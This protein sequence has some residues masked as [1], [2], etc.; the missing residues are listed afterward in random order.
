MAEWTGILE[1]SIFV[2]DTLRC[3]ATIAAALT[4]SPVS[5]VFSL[6][7]VIP[8]DQGDWDSNLPIQ[9]NERILSGTKVDSF[10][11][12]YYYR[13]HVT[14]LTIA[15]GAI[16]SEVV[17]TFI[18]WNA[19]FDEVDML[20]IVE[21]GGD[22]FALAGQTAPYTFKPLEYET[23]TVTVPKEG[24]P[25]LA[26]SI[27]FDFDT[28][29]DRTVLITGIRMIV[30]AFCPQVEMK[31]MLE[32][33]TDIIMPNDG[34]GSEQRICVRQIPRQSFTL[35]VP[36]KTEKEQARFEAAMF[37]WQKR[38]FGL[39]I[40]TERVIHTAAINA[41]DMTI[42]IDTTNADFRDDSYAVIW[43][44]LTEYEA[45]KIT[46]VAANLLTLESPVVASYTGTKFI[47]PCRIAQVPTAARKSNP[48]AAVAIADISFAI[49]DNILLTGYTPETTYLGLP[50]LLVG[51][52][53]FGGSPK[54][55]QI[56]SDSFT[57][58]YESG[59]F[60]YFSDSE[61]NLIS[62][63]W[64]FVNVTR[65]QCWNFRKFLHSLYGRQGTFWAP[66]YKRDLIQAETIGA[67]DTNFQIENIKLAEN[68]TFN[69][70]RNHLAFIFTS[71]TVL[72]RAITGIVESDEDIEIV[73]I[74]SALGVEVDI[75]DCVISFLDLCRLASDSVELD[76]FFFDK[77]K[78][79]T[80]F[81]TV[82]E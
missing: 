27:E 66:T 57:Q 2:E 13:V 1:P 16:L 55:S 61:F 20:S 47:L 28:G 30:F 51:S 67:A 79:E 54:E 73:S 53:Q 33:L 8:I 45:V 43:K 60:D 74:D 75:G 12:D 82:K 58:D 23:Y 81:L 35:S 22:E 71:G 44:S 26:S 41:T 4:P 29:E 50:V 76:W 62:Q 7:S 46:T 49:K 18:V 21:T 56:D 70:L 25:N 52:K 5:P 19:W 59:D 40:W 6:E 37:G 42:T 3:S 68:M 14:P 11:D 32:G 31:E 77:N 9:E 64:G 65:A 39:P 72:Y 17:D 10:L 63:G 78:C 24:I 34:I 69:T 36:L 15:F 38:Y 48:V 80:T